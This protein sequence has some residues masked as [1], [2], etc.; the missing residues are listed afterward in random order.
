MDATMNIVNCMRL[1]QALYY[2]TITL[3]DYTQIPR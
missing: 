3:Q 2:Y 1:A